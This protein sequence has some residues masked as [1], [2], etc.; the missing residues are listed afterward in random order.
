MKY[1]CLNQIISVIDRDF[2]TVIFADS[3]VHRSPIMFLNAES[4][5][6]TPTIEG[7]W[8]YTHKF[9]TLMA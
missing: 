9:T 4:E 5:V 6:T 2:L 1:C 7:L 3:I 8:V